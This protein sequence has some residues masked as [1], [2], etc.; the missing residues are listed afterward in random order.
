MKIDLDKINFFL[1]KKYFKNQEFF[2][3]SGDWDKR[4]RNITDYK[5][6]NINY[7]SV[8][9]IFEQKKSYKESD[10]YKEKLKELSEGGKTSRGHKNVEELNR[11]FESLFELNSSLKEYGYKNQSELNKKDSVDE[12]GVIIGRQGEIIKL[13]D[14][15][16]GTHRFAL[17]K[18]LNIKE[19][20]ISVK[21]IHSKFIDK[22]KLEAL[23][24]NDNFQNIK[25][26]LKEELYKKI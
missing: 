7:N 25:K 18:I 23:L 16:G 10:E 21:A 24:I 8:F 11:Y 15:F 4:K 5:N 3:W 9:Q 14:K 17:C 22:K 12:I 19:I 26:H 1:E 13:D 6:F 2:L 20:T